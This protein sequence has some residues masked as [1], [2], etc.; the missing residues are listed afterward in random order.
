WY[1]APV[2]GLN[3]FTNCI[4]LRAT[5]GDRVGMKPNVETEPS[6]PWLINLDL[7]SARTVKE[8]SNSLW[9]QQES[10]P[11]G[12]TLT[13]KVFG[14]VKAGA[15]ASGRAGGAG[16]SVKI[17]VTVNAPGL[18]LGRLV[19][20]A[21]W[22]AGLAG[23]TPTEPPVRIA[24]DGEDLGA[25][26]PGEPAGAVTGPVPGPFA[27]ITTPLSAVLRRCN[28]DSQN[29]YAECLLKRTAYEVTQQPGSWATGSQVVTMRLTEKLGGEAQSIRIV[30]G[31]GMSRDNQVSPM[32]VARWLGALQQDRALGSAF[33]ASM[34]RADDRESKVSRRFIDH[35]LH[36]TVYAKTG[37]IKNVVCLSGYVVTGRPGGDD[38][39]GRTIAFSVLANDVGGNGAKVKDFQEEVVMVIDKWLSRQSGG[40]GAARAN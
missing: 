39:P 38:G 35:R 29:L 11:G 17:D 15:G 7:S 21:M 23:A 26:R 4:T 30:D 9:S 18:L 37:Y 25:P 2:S 8:G 28:V 12:G 5:A 6:A 24:A 20:H 16:P 3:F 34:A 1:C 36:N 40:S 31:S 10:G 14:D 22:E 19:S 32:V 27:V 13:F 33:I